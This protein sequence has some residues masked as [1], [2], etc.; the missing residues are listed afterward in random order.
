MIKLLLNYFT[1]CAYFSRFHA[2]LKA[3]FYDIYMI[4]LIV[5]LLKRC[6]NRGKQFSHLQDMETSAIIGIIITF[7]SD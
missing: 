3:K 2:P 1:I 6:H 4:K 7:I 5:Y